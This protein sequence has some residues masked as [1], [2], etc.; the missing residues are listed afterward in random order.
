MALTRTKKLSSYAPESKASRFSQRMIKN[1]IKNEC[2]IVDVAISSVS[3][4][5]TREYEKLDKYQDLAREFK[6]LWNVNVRVIPVIIGALGTIP[7]DLHKR[8]KEIGFL[9]EDCRTAENSYSSL[10]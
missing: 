9:V 6:K 1:K 2:Q 8:L 7:R 10:C 5:E 3:R 4:I